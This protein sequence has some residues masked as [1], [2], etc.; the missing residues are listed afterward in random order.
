M[1]QIVHSLTKQRRF[2]MILGLLVVFCLCLGIIIVPIEQAGP[3]AKIRTT[4]DGIWWAVTTITSVGYG[5]VYPVTALGRGV[6]II[7]E[8]V[9]V[10]AFGLLIG[11]MTVALAE[12]KER[13]YWTRIFNRLDKIEEQLRAAEKREQFVVKNNL[14]ED[15]E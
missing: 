1:S 14:E 10:V 13:F 11:I 5:D 12:S 4:Y 2:K 6:G 7:L 8:V 15:R 9:G 3:D